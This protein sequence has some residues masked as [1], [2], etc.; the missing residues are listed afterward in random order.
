MAENK[1][2]F[3]GLVNSLLKGMDTALSTKTVVGGPTQV[4]DGTVII[5]LVDVSF[6]FAA[7]AGAN[8]QKD[9][10]S[11]AGGLGGKMSPSAILVIKDG[12]VKLINVKN[13]DTV[14]KVL[15]M[16]P[17]LVDKFTKKDEMSDKEVRDI[18]FPE[19]EASNS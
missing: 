16:L 18:A 12:N 7:G 5:P 14:T 10:N 3:D 6:G 1:A 17:E 8:G 15:D 19:E 4:G 11:G 13:Q 9:S 2:N